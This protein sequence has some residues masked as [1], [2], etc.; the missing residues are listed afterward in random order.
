MAR[1]SS[2]ARMAAWSATL[3]FVIASFS[4]C[5]SGTG[6]AANFFPIPSS[7]SLAPAPSVSLEL[8]TN[9]A[10]IAT[11][12]TSSNT[13][14]VQPVTYQSSNTAIVTVAANG[15]ACAGTWNSLSNPQVC[16]P[17]PTGV[18]QVTATAQGV[19]S[20]PTTIYVHQHIDQVTV[21]DICAVN[22]PPAACTVPRNPLC[23]SLNQNNLP[24][25]TVYEAHAFSQ[26]TDVT[27][28]AGQFTWQAVNTTV[29]GLSSSV[30]T[31]ANFVNGL[32]LNQVVATARIPGVTP[33]IASI[34]TANSAPVNFTTCAVQSI[35][36][37]LTE[38]SENSRTYAPTVLDTAGNIV[39]APSSQVTV[40]LTWSSSAP[41]SISVSTSGV[42]TGTLAGSAAAIIA[43]CTP[44]TCNIGFGSASSLGR[45]LPI[46]PENAGEL[47]VQGSQGGQPADATVY[48]TST[49]CG[50]TENCVSVV[51]PVVIPTNA[52]Q[53]PITLPATP[54]SMVPNLQGTN[55]YLGTNSGFLGTKGLM[56]LNTTAGT[57]TQFTST[58]GKV[59][60][61]SPDGNLV[62]VSDTTDTPNQVFVFNTATNSSTALS[63]TGATAAAFSPDS[64]KAYIAA[65]STLYVFSKQDA[66]QTIALAAP[67]ND[68]AFFAE[69][70]FAYLA[71]GDPAG[72][73]VRTT[74]ANGV[75]TTVP[76]PTIPSFIRAL[77]DAAHMF[78][79]E[80]PDVSVIDV[81]A[82]PQGC[83]PTVSNSPLN[84]DLG[85]G[86]F[87]PSQVLLS[88]DGSVAYIFSP[89]FKTVPIFNVLAETSS[90]ITIAR[91]AS[92]LQAGISA[93]GTMV[94]IGATDGNLHVIQTATNADTQQIKFTQ[95]FCQTPGGQSFGITCN[96][97]LVAVK[98]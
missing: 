6:A 26:G 71:G 24:Q 87:T 92:P 69:G 47:I 21:R 2:V 55:I 36:L 68:V 66:L 3:V 13:S 54:D 20:P 27:P 42:A 50:T 34:G 7:I 51:I 10:F 48:A 76:T 85:Q 43:S 63:I 64:L 86:T 5:H 28:T 49:A 1:V 97:D 61:V 33:V 44:P 29:A 90:S 41:A 14:S 16:T 74:C 53:T 62:I 83:P 72:V 19:S 65:G 75:V 9:Q 93:D 80:P 88:P 25:N 60:T 39:M 45:S 58:P 91:N 77:P 81:T 37:Q 79:V 57:V 17:G 78:T 73:Q 38:A 31:L 4:G 95:S 35:K 70:A 46:Y 96:P 84:F 11:V 15:L 23:Q 12:N 94:A 30:N 89:S 40:P 18:A 59:L 32:S 22:E 52:E 8:G 82:T 98:P 56:V 67:A